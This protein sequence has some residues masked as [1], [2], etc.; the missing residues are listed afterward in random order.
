MLVQSTTDVITRRGG[1]EMAS[2]PQQFKSLHTLKFPGTSGTCQGMP[3]KKK[4]Y[5]TLASKKEKST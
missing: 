3:S 1:Q 4:C 5:V 2:T